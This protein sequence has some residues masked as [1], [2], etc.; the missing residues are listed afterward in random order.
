MIHSESPP[1]P[2]SESIAI[3]QVGSNTFGAPGALGALDAFGAIVAL[4]GN[5]AARSRVPRE[6][7]VLGEKVW[8]S[9][10]RQ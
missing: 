9:D 4:S 5:A 3:L 10:L 8:D 7:G 6:R 1:G 2:D